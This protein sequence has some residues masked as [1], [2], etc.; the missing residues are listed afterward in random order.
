M[1]DA[2]ANPALQA[3]KEAWTQLQACLDRRESFIFEAGAGAGK[4]YS[5]IE[6]LRYL[7][8]RDGIELMR[9]NQRVACITYTNVATNEIETRTDRHPAIYSSTIHSFCWKLI[10]DFQPFLRK[11]IPNI[12]GWPE[13]LR[14][15]AQRG[16]P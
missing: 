14:E 13:R 15:S 1:T 10:Q 2:I 5:L 12:E 7:I 11:E 6:A 3:A 16:Y 8:K 4:T 9:N